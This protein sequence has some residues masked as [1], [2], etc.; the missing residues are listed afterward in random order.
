MNNETTTTAAR[1]SSLKFNGY[2]IELV[3]N[4]K[5]QPVARL[6][7][8]LTSGPNKGTYKP[9][10]GYFFATEERRAE[11]V[12]AK[13]QKAKE[14]ETRKNDEKATK[15]SAQKNMINPFKVGEVFYSSWGYDQT[16]IDFY[17][18]AEVKAKS[19]V[20][21]RICGEVVEGT[22]G[23]DSCNVRPIAGSFTDAKPILSMVRASVYQGKTSYRISDGRHG[24]YPYDRGERGVYSSWGH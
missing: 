13:M 20:L 7:K 14:W 1:I 24:L 8:L 10:E 5:G 12:A 4:V 6:F 23:H 16:N 19:V 22:G 2:K 17:E 15:A 9:L 11:Y 3:T 18:I 21:R